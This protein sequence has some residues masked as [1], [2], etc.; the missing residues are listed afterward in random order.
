MRKALSA[1]LAVLFLFPLS[2]CAPDAREEIADLQAWYAGSPGGRLEFTAEYRWE[3]E[4]QSYG[5][6]YDGGAR[7]GTVT[8][9]EPEALAG[10]VLS[11]R[12]EDGDL[13]YGTLTVETGRSGGAGITPA[14]IGPVLWELWSLGYATQCR[15]DRLDGRDALFCLLEK[16]GV[17]AE[18]WFDG[19]TY[20]P[21]R[22]EFLENGVTVL[23]CAFTQGP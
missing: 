12:Q 9:L 7:G 16:R 6:R 4:S 13:R 15:R 14:G 10:L 19:E 8:V 2:G 21:L 1:V 17:L 5:L 20:A 22:C 3:T 11:V 23:T 18:C